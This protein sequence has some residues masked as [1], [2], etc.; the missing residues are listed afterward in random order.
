MSL[1]EIN[2][3]SAKQFVE[4][5]GDVAEHSPWVAEAAAKR[6]PFDDREAMLEAFEDAVRSA[7]AA[8]QLQLLC[9]HPDLAGRARAITED[10]SREQKGAGLDALSREEF[11]RFTNLNERY[12]AQFGFPFIFAVKGA[13]KHQILAAFENRIG[14]SRAE[15]LHNALSQ[16]SRILRF[17]LED[18]I[19]Q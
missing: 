1:N 8:R 13:T 18:R 12:R 14:N 5:F 6:R 17:R 10:S 11:T 4:C 15:E 7:A 19:E 3:M 9:A 2:A 16:V